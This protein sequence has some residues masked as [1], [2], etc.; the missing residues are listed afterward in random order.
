VSGAFRS[1]VSAALESQVCRRGTR[2]AQAVRGLDSFSAQPVRARYSP[3]GVPRSVARVQPDDATAPHG[4]GAVV[5]IALMGWARQPRQP[6]CPSLPCG[7]HTRQG[8]ESVP[9]LAVAACRDAESP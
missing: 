2:K 4:G 9:D 6:P 1:A 5:S 3:P 8:S 7:G